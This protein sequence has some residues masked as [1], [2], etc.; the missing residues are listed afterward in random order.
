MMRNRSVLTFV[1]LVFAVIFCVST[2]WRMQAQDNSEPST[3]LPLD[4]YLMDRDAEIAMARSAAP[5]SIAKDAT[6]MTLGRHGYET[7]VEGKNGFVCMVGRSWDLPKNNPAF[8]DPK[9][10]GTV[11]FNAAAARWYLL[12]Y[13]KKTELALA[14]RS[15]TQIEDV[16]TDGVAEGELPTPEPGSMAYMMSKQAYLNASIKGPWLPHVMFYVPE[17]D[18]K[19]VG[20][21]LGD[22]VPLDATEVKVGRYTVIDVPVS[23]WSDGT[24]SPHSGGRH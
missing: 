2:P 13:F 10:H 14:G 17:I 11:C 15:N 22:D 5:P 16:I 7:A 21:D 9:I 1:S 19:A 20:S 23:N 12:T 4:Q 3:M 6:I 24:P 8:W 18:P